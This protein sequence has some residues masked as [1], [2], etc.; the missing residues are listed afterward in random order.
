MPYDTALLVLEGHR[1]VAEAL[2]LEL[3]GHAVA[4]AR[5]DGFPRELEHLLT[6]DLELVEAGGGEDGCR[7][8]R[9]HTSHSSVSSMSFSAMRSVAW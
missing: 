4:L 7:K 5:H 8:D 3:D 9:S 1:H 6:L 2:R